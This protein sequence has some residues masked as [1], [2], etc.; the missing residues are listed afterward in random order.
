MIEGRSAR[1]GRVE[2]P[3]RPDPS[4]VQGRDSSRPRSECDGRFARGLD[5]RTEVANVR[6]SRPRCGGVCVNAASGRPPPR[7]DSDQTCPCGGIAHDLALPV[8]PHSPDRVPAPPPPRRY[9]GPGQGPRARHHH[10][11]HHPSHDHVFGFGHPCGDVPCGCG[12]S[13]G[14]EHTLVLGS[15][16]SSA[17]KTPA[18]RGPPVESR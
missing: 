9:L 8:A 18:A 15:P 7:V 3:S 17:Q 16:Q 5:V 11:H 10:D 4:A 13:V 1:D 12:W 6:R 14:C 2:P